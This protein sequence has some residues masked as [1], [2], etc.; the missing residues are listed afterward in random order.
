M[1][2]RL[3]KILLKTLVLLAF[4]G[5]SSQ[6]NSGW[7]VTDLGTLGN[8]PLF[9]NTNP[10]LRHGWDGSYYAI[11]LGRV[12]TTL[13]YRFKIMA[14]SDV[15]IRVAAI[16]KPCHQNTFIPAFTVWATAGSFDIVKHADQSVYPRPYSPWGFVDW[17]YNG[18]QG[19]PTN[20]STGPACQS[21]QCN[22]NNWLAPGV[23]G[24]SASDGIT[25]LVGYAN[26]GPTGWVNDNGD[27]VGSGRVGSDN[28][29]PLEGLVLVQGP[30]YDPDPTNTVQYAS[31]KLYNLSPG[32]YVIA[33]GGSCRDPNAC[34][35]KP[36]VYSTNNDYSITV[37]TLTD[38]WGVI[39]QPTTTPPNQTTYP[40][41]SGG[42]SGSQATVT[43]PAV[44]RYFGNVRVDSLL[45][46]ISNASVYWDATGYEQF[47]VEVEWFIPW[48]Y[49]VLRPPIIV[50]THS[51]V[52]NLGNIALISAIRVTPM[53]DGYPVSSMAI[54]IPYTQFT[55]KPSP[56]FF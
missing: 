39:P 50:N 44:N 2:N 51:V 52:F 32:T 40:S 22:S 15:E 21:G 45:P 27:I 16:G 47:A 38:Q 43:N 35:M 54:T 41:S 28:Q 23:S 13:F 31:L 37:S 3:Y 19:A 30:N 4:L 18:V 12:N 24:V 49:P 6:A 56:F 1:D 8:K 46:L 25:T 34:A 11:K 26:A 7:Y 14:T 10:G 17:V 42:E 53:Q 33:S 5:V 20:L 9:N 48:V 55:Y 29:G 36:G